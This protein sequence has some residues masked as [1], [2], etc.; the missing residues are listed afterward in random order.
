MKKIRV[1]KNCNKK[2]QVWS[3]D[4][5]ISFALF[6]FALL[7]AFKV[8]GS[9]IFQDE[10]PILREEAES[11]SEQ[12]MSPGYPS[13]WTTAN[14]VQPGILTN[15]HLSKKKLQ[16]LKDWSINTKYNYAISVN[17][18][19]ETIIPIKGDCVISNI[20]LSQTKS[21]IKKNLSSAYYYKTSSDLLFNATQ[22]GFDIYTDFSLLKDNLLQ[23]DFLV[24]EEP[25]LSYNPDE[26]VLDFEKKESLEEFVLMGNTLVLTGD[27]GLDLFNIQTNISFG[28]ANITLNDEFLNLSEGTNITTAGS[29]YSTNSTGINNYLTI[30]KLA[31]GQDLISKIKYG[32]GYVYYFGTTSG[33]VVDLGIPLKERIGESMLNSSKE[34]TVNCVSFNIPSSENVAVIKRIS[35][36]KGELVEIKVQSWT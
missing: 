20:A 11:L 26:E 32:D 5:A 34:N 21:A 31:N 1:R 15:N 4:Y 3:I 7:I 19:N 14:I 30:A 35:S 25:E 13:Y 18:L 17:Y 8:I 9:E 24:M 28:N 27:I 16:Y 12:L 23:Y 33:T 2:G 29:I 22:L 6:I 10:F 36:Y